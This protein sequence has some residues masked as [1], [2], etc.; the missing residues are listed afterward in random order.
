MHQE[1]KEGSSVR[2][3]RRGMRDGIPI[4]AGYFAVAFALGITAKQMGLS[5]LQSAVMSLTML[6][7]AGEFAAITVIGGNAGLLV[8]AVTTVVVNMRYLLMSTA[9]SQKIE[10]R[11]GFAKRLMMSYCVTDEIFALA[12][13]VKG[14]LDPMYNVGM[15]V[16]AAP[17]WTAGTA[18]GAALGSILPTAA[19]NALGVALYGM[20]LAVI[21]PPARKNLVIAAVVIISMLSSW[22]MSI[23]PVLR[24]ISSGTRIIILTLLIASAAAILRPV[25]EEEG[26]QAS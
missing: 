10:S 25:K 11:T 23:L 18:L 22:L 9:L 14:K 16:V 15:A 4:S 26:G 8:M 5:V 20:F 19:A 24:E 7:S 12:V 21:I 3:F 6:A 1:E 17:G 2:W 13:T